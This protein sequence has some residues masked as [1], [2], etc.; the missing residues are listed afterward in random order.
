MLAAR[1]STAIF[2]FLIALTSLKGLCLAKEVC[3]RLAPTAI[4]GC[5][6]LSAQQSPPTVN[7][8]YIA[9]SLQHAR[10]QTA[11]RTSRVVHVHYNQKMTAD[12]KLYLSQKLL[13]NGNHWSWP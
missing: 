8:S 4:F 1:S 2:Y 10:T 11:I 12:V 9:L 3:Q 13:R 6:S 5:A 7:F